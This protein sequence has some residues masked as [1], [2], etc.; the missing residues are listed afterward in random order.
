[1]LI[2]HLIVGELAT[3]C[4]LLASG[5]ELVIIDPGGD[6]DKIVLEIKKITAEPKY[7]IN[8]H[9]HW[10]HTLVNEKIKKETGAKILIH[11]AE[12]DFINFKADVFLKEGDEIKIGDSALKVIH[13]PGHTEG[14]ICLLGE[15]F[16]LT[17][18]TL[19]K[20]GY[21]RTDLPGGSQKKIEQSL[22]KLS[23][24]LKPGMMVYPGHGEIF[25]VK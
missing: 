6:A 12:K 17:G 22:E 18:D 1:M 4:Y 14:G 20:D 25:K 2:K 15:D 24:I 21:G 7:I 5:N 13:T 3:N 23:R 10:D 19:F 9:Y 11:E 8:T 16:I